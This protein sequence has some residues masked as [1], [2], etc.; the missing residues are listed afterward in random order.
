MFNEI[1]K[2]MHLNEMLTSATR[3]CVFSYYNIENEDLYAEVHL[4]TTNGDGHSREII[5]VTYT[6]TLTP[7]DWAAEGESLEENYLLYALVSTV[8]RLAKV[9]G[10]NKRMFKASLVQDFQ[11]EALRLLEDMVGQLT[12]EEAINLLYGKALKAPAGRD[13]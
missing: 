8:R 3:V 6:G 5:D 1:K 4:I 9:K 7:A 2:V 11:D 10:T 12:R 13:L